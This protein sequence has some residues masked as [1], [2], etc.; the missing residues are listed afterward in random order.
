VI[1]VRPSVWFTE[2]LMMSG[3]ESRRTTAI[4]AHRSKIN[5]SLVE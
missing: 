3:I 1:T 5:V 2:A 4:F